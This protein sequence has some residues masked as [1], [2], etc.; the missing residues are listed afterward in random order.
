LQIGQKPEPSI[1]HPATTS[2]AD[3]IVDLD[4]LAVDFVHDE[5]LAE[6]FAP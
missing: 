6:D 3:E 2:L 5:A 4:N 1:E